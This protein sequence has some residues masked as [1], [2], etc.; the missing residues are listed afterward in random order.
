MVT[1]RQVAANRA[2][3]RRSTGPRS[4]GGKKRVSGNTYRHGL[5]LTIS[6][7]APYTKSVDDL[8]KKIARGAADARVL[9]RARAVAE[10]EL[11]LRRVR[12]TKM[13]LIQRVH[14]FGALDPVPWLKGWPEKAAIKLCDQGLEP[15]DPIERASTMPTEEPDRTAEAVRRVLPELRMLDRYERRAAARRRW[16]IRAFV[17]VTKLEV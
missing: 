2:N 15:P 1:E 14:A 13:T 4:I 3:A 16:A 7:I 12:T 17:E 6:S 8:A 5:S 9:Q 11:D 10:A